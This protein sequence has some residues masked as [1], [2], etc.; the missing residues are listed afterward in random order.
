MFLLRKPSEYILIGDAEGKHQSSVYKGKHLRRLHPLAPLPSGYITVTK[1]HNRP[2]YD[3]RGKLLPK[4][5]GLCRIF[6]EKGKDLEG[7]MSE[8]LERLI[9]EIDKSKFTP[10]EVAGFT[11]QPHLALLAGAAIGYKKAL[12]DLGEMLPDGEKLNEIVKKAVF[13]LQQRESGV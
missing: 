3:E 13:H 9:Q 1:I 6:G 12:D 7:K 10:A 8:L 4:Y 11:A 2:V 5:W